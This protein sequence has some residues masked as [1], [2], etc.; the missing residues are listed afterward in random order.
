MTVDMEKCKRI[1]QYFWDPE[2]KND[3]PAA[4]IWCLGR[5]Y[6]LQTKETQS[7]SKF[8]LNEKGK[9]YVLISNARL[10]PMNHTD[11]SKLMLAYRVIHGQRSL[12]PISALESGLLTDPISHLF[13]EPE[14]RKHPPP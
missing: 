7:V 9:E 13:H 10:Q 6:V 2:P 4:V 5:E 3:E 1:V 11:K 14:P 12:S 8:G